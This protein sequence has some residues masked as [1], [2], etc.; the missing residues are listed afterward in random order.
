MTE[1]I[2]FSIREQEYIGDEGSQQ[3]E[4]FNT[5][6]TDNGYKS[7]ILKQY[8]SDAISEPFLQ[9]WEHKFIVELENLPEKS[10]GSLSI[11]YITEN[12]QEDDNNTIYFYTKNDKNQ[13][14]NIQAFITYDIRFIDPRNKTQPF[15]YV[16]TFAVNN[17]IPIDQR[18]ISGANIFDW[19]YKNAMHDGFYCIKID[20]LSSAINFWR[21][22]SRFVYITDRMNEVKKKNL[23]TLDQLFEQERLFKATPGKEAELRKITQS[24]KLTKGLIG[25][26]PMKRTKSQN[27]ADSSLPSE[28]SRESSIHL[29]LDEGSDKS[30]EWHSLSSNH[31]QPWYSPESIV[32]SLSYDSTTVSPKKMIAQLNKQFASPQIKR[33]HSLP[34]RKKAKTPNPKMRTTKSAHF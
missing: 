21:N 20:A 33:R 8:A 12:I 7:K 5:K 17:S 11:D 34:T 19:F 24:I 25:Q 9:R 1:P 15:I 23:E 30:I 18:R 14:K 16:H 13:L 26:V 27:S 10:F 2:Y 22:K 4:R 29:N 28:N 6:L 32:S 31:S 3:A